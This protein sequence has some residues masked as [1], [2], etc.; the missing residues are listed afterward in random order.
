M[1][2]YQFVVSLAMY[3]HSSFSTCSAASVIVTYVKLSNS[4]EEKY[5]FIG[6]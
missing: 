5:Y 6:F 4:G 1:W 3:E 2:V